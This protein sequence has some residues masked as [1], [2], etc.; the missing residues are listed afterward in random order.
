MIALTVARLQRERHEST[1]EQQMTA[2]DILTEVLATLDRAANALSTA[3]Y[4]T[5]DPATASAV[6]ADSRAQALMGVLADH[7][8]AIRLDSQ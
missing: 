1:R 7:L 8:A 5:A 3:R 4:M 6:A 2:G